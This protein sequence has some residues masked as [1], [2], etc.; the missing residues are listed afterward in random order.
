[1]QHPLENPTL[2]PFGFAFPES[3]KRL[4]YVPEITSG[5]N[6][7]RIIAELWDKWNRKN[8]RYPLPVTEIIHRILPGLA[9]LNQLRKGDFEFDGRPYLSRDILVLSSLV[10]WLATNVGGCFLETDISSRKDLPMKY[11]PEREFLIK[12]ELEKEHHAGLQ[13]IPAFIT[14][15]C[16]NR[17]KELWRC[18]HGVCHYNPKDVSTRDRAVVDGLMRWLATKQG[19]AFTTRYLKKRKNAQEAAWQKTHHEMDILRNKVA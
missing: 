15:V 16:T 13:D 8:S 17:C 18:T 14:H 6:C 7:E 12:C 5:V 10:Q 1:M 2:A 11:H 19:R 9:T 4:E 3:Q